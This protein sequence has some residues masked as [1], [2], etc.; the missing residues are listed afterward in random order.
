M[1]F[2]TLGNESISEK[3]INGNVGISI[4]LIQLQESLPPTHPPTHLPSPK[5]R[6]PPYPPTHPPTSLPPAHLPTSHPRTSLIH[7]W[8]ILTPPN[9]VGEGVSTSQEGG[10]E[11]GGWWGRKSVVGW[12]TGWRDRRNPPPGVRLPSQ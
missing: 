10:R 5:H 7:P 3:N 8:L 9:P 1:L 11:V 6:T 4:Q 12:G 2:C